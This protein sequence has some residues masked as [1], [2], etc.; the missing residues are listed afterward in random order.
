M[1]G[2][3]ISSSKSFLVLLFFTAIATSANAQW[4]NNPTN[5]HWYRLTEG[6]YF[7][8]HDESVNVLSP[9]WFDAEAE[10]QS[11]NPEGHL[12]TINDQAEN[13][14]LVTTF[15]SGTCFWIGFTDHSAYSTEGSWV[16]VS[17]EDVTF[18]NWDSIQPD[19][20][21]QGEDCAHLIHFGSPDWN[22]LGN[23]NSHG[24]GVGSPYRGIV[25]I[26]GGL[27]PA[28]LIGWDAVKALFR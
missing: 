20:Y 3:Q 13:D 11:Y 23:D 8:I 28:D 6:E 1:G 21:L 2:F 12:V 24:A 25:E 18:I 26:H 14:W 16:W 4:V 7:G 17:G 9:D 22:D 27:V 10:A 15:G 19:N 5:G